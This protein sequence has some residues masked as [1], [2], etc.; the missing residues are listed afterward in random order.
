MRLGFTA[1]GIAPTEYYTFGCAMFFPTATYSS[2]ARV[3]S[4]Q[5]AGQDEQQ[6]HFDAAGVIQASK[7]NQSSL[8]RSAPGAYPLNQWFYL[9]VQ[10]RHHSSTGSFKIWVNGNLIINFTGNTKY[11]WT[12]IDSVVLEGYHANARY[13]D[14]YL[15]TDTVADPPFGDC[16]VD[17]LLPTGNGAASQ[18]VGSDGNSTDNYALIDENPQSMTDY[19]SSATPG[20]QDLYTVADLSITLGAIQAVGVCLTAHKDEV[21]P[22]SVK[23]LVRRTVTNAGTVLPLEGNAAGRQAFFLTDP[24]TGAAWTQANVNA[25]QFGI[26]VV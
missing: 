14:I 11:N 17:L 12:M 10:V 3:I 9:E 21:G 16:S 24:E 1:N 8:G 25:A 6:I 15:C 13:D 18:W 5:V 2:I 20:Q 23:P 22:R 4:F 7:F 19:V 26:E